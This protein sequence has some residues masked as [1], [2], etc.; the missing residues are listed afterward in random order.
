MRKPGV[1][2]PHW[3]AGGPGTPPG[4]GAIGAGLREAL[5]RRDLV[6]ISLDGE[7]QARAH[8]LA[9]D[10][11]GACAAHAVL[12]SEVGAVEFGVLA[13]EVGEETARLDLGLQR[14]AV[15]DGA[16]DPRQAA[17][18]SLTPAAAAASARA[19]STPA[20]LRR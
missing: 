16:H 8:R 7:H 13:Q 10:E 2:N 19:A 1:Q 6:A 9:V 3:S 20:T 17:V 14:A 15:H 4:A 12:A 18:P 5:D 11:H